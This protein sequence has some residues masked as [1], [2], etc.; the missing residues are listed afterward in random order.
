MEKLIAVEEAKR[1]L[2]E[3]KDWSLWRWLIEKK[4]VREATDVATAAHFELEK[5]VKAGWSDA[6]KKAYRELEAQAAADG[7]PSARRKYEKAKEDAKEVCPAVKLAAWRVKDA[8]DKY[9]AARTDAEAT[10]DE[11]EKRMSGALAREG[12]QKAID[13]Y[14]LREK[15]IRRAEEAGRLK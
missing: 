12:A 13:A 3:G 8:D 15:A 6:L 1:L 11:A 7:N 9:S 5:K 10:F 4:R 14:N 2:N